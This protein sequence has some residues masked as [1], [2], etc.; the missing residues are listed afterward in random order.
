[1][2]FDEVPGL[3]F[4]SRFSLG[5]EWQHDEPR[6]SQGFLSARLR[7]PLQIFG[8]PSSDRTPME[9]RMAGPVVRDVDV[10]SQSGAFG[11]PETATANASG[12]EHRTADLRGVKECVS[13]VRV[14]GRP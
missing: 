2:V 7:I 14:K 13:Q 10:V 3:W 12:G 1:M 9:R 11:K 6:G 4:G 8:Q 5:A